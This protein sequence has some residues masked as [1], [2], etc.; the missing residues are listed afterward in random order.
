MQN[1]LLTSYIYH[2][3][4]FFMIFFTA[5]YMSWINRHVEETKI[6]AAASQDGDHQQLQTSSELISKLM[7]TG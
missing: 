3:Y 2:M 5:M 7:K 4:V 1:V 6:A